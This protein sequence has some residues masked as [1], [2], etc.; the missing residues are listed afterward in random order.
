MNKKYI[1]V[2]DD[3]VFNVLGKNVWSFEEVK[4]KFG[5]VR[6][7]LG[8]KVRL[9]YL[10]DMGNNGRELVRVKNN[11]NECGYS[12]MCI[13]DLECLNVKYVEVEGLFDNDEERVIKSVGINYD[14]DE[15]VMD[16]RG[17]IEMY[18][19]FFD[20]GDVVDF[21]EGKK[22]L[23]EFGGSDK[24]VVKKISKLLEKLKKEV[25]GYEGEKVWKLWEVEYD[26]NLGV[27]LK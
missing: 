14:G 11:L 21:E 1:V 13:I 9:D 22:E 5:N 27:E 17:G 24:W 10:I 6:D 7:V 2:I 23:I 12:E 4:E 20:E 19:R 26:L 18:E 3:E 15:R 8:K 16:N 25:D